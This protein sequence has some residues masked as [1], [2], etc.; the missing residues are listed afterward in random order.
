M[1][2][3]TIRLDEAIFMM[4]N[5]LIPIGVSVA[6]A[7]FSIATLL[8]LKGKD[9]LFPSIYLALSILVGVAFQC[10]YSYLTSNYTIEN[11]K[12]NI[13][14]IGLKNQFTIGLGGSQYVFYTGDTVTGLKLRHLPSRLSNV[15]YTND[16]PY[17]NIKMKKSKSKSLFQD[18]HIE[19]DSI[20][21]Y[22]PHNS[23]IQEYDLSLK[24]R[25]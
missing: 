6:V 3:K 10:Q 20:D 14:S 23:I 9:R 21:I 18:Y 25:K 2:F 12:E 15:K 17:V 13:Y 19:V 22:V 7:L 4:K 11:V 1:D 8:K 5:Y 16:E 24:S